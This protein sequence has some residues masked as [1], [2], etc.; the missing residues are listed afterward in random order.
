MNL[1]QGIHYGLIAD[2]VQEILPGLVKKAIQPAKHE[3]N[4]VKGKII[5]DAVEFNTVNYIELI[6]ILIGA[7]KEQQKKIDELETKLAAI[8]KRLEHQ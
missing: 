8:E 6:P 4:D 5:A 3:N 7:V 1:P 2:E